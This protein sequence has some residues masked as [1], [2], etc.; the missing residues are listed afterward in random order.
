MGR[1]VATR[2]ASAP[3]GL[4]LYRREGRDGYFFVK[5][6]AAQAKRFSGRISPAY[7]NEQIKRS[8]GTLVTRQKEA[9][10][11]CHRRNAEIQEMLLALAGDNVG[12]SGADLEGISRQLA[13]Q[14]IRGHQRGMNLQ[15]LDLE[16][17]GELATLIS[18]RSASAGSHQEMVELQL[19]ETTIEVPEADRERIQTELN[20]IPKGEPVTFRVFDTD[21]VARERHKLEK[22]CWSSGFR[23][24]PN[25]LDAIAARF[26]TLVSD[27][28]SNAE[29][30][31]IAGAL[32]PPKPTLG[33]K[34]VT[35]ERLLQ[36][37]IEEGASAGY[38]KVFR[39]A[40][41]RLQGW[42]EHQHN[43]KLPTA[44]DSEIAQQYRRWLNSEAS[45][46]KTST[47]ARDIRNLNAVMNAAVNQQVIQ[48]NPF[49]NLPK[50][51]RASMQQKLD[52]R[53][54]VDT[55]KIY[56]AEETRKINDTMQKD[57][58]GR[59]DKGFD[60]FYL[61][62]AT[63]T[64]IQEVAGL[65]KCDFTKRVFNGVEY[66]C[67]EIRRWHGRGFGVMGER[68][69]LKT[70][71]SERIIPLPTCAHPIW[72]LHHDPLSEHPAF[73]DEAPPTDSTGQWGDN[74]GRRMRN[75]IDGWKGTHG[76][77]E[78]MINNL[79]NNAIPIRIVEMVTG[80][81]GKTPLSMYTSDDLPSMAKAIEL[82]AKLLEIPDYL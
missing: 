44:I 78:T 39:K 15:N 6:L 7:I 77:R 37:K 19:G 54:T 2:V 50:D 40:L 1:D 57:K 69:G 10:A 61:Q 32:E 68:G 34:G 72:D 48:I 59:K 58:R 25:D 60:L 56:N 3:R 41:A 80:K 63:G 8:D 26:K 75:K 28:F 82:H 67:I 5:N 13:D 76:W 71:Q 23:P 66:K 38:E 33:K 20:A 70:P 29:K 81:S 42:M 49:K 45:G 35:W 18:T 65:R 43:T 14:W 52:A 46:L 74:L 22:L 11:Y 4:G 53:K 24:C 17:L 36:A 64:R 79:L 62:A 31:Q 73:P 47:A 30:A 9:E 51:R 55:N 16:V 27:H 21:G 12:Y